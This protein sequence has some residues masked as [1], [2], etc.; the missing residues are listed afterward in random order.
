MEPQLQ[1]SG[2]AHPQLWWLERDEI[3]SP[4]RAA[5]SIEWLWRFRGLAFGPLVT[6]FDIASQYGNRDQ[7]NEIIRSRC[8]EFLFFWPDLTDNEDLEKRRTFW[9]VRAWYFLDKPFDACWDW[10]KADKNTLLVL[11][12]HSGRMSRSDHPS[13]PKLTS[14]KVEAIVDAFIDRWPKINLP[15]QYGSDSPDEETAYRFLTEVIWYIGTDNPDEAIPVLDKLLAD[16]RCAELHNNLKSIRASQIRIKALRDFEPPSP[17][18]IV[19]LL[20]RDEVVSVEGLRELVL[21]E[22]QDFQKSIDGGEFNSASR[23][24]EQGKRLGEVR[25]TEIVAERLSLR[26]QPKGISVTPEHQLKDA[27][28]SDFTV[29]K[30][31]G[32]ARRLLVTEVKGQWHDEL[33]S[34][35]SAQ[36]YERYSIHPDAEQQGVFLVIWFGAEEKVAGLRRHGIANADQLKK[37]VEAQIPPQLSGL[38]DVFVLDVSRT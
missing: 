11:H 6:L 8:A 22:L 5:L 10:L 27:N 36:L 35:A 14:T 30:M 2:C 31:I 25:S 9:F 18:E 7:L 12:N 28:R 20:D 37:S 32:G 34:A 13:W 26:L 15:N 33:Y 17:P 3:F 19:K 38:I 23:F 16:T 4:L 24:Y 29:T 1:I 21:Q